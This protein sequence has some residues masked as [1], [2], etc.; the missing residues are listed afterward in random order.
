MTRDEAEARAA[1]LSAA[2]PDHSFFARERGGDW[3][4]VKVAAMPGRPRKFGTAT[5]ARPRPDADDPR[6]STDRLIP[7]F[8]PGLG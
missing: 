1:E 4:I 5:E 3:E 2:E 8:G 6:T 7:P